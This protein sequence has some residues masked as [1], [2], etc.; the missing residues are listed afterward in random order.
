[1]AKDIVY[2]PGMQPEIKDMCQNCGQCAQFGR[3]NTREPMKSQPIPQYPWQFVSQDIFQFESSSYLVTVDHY[4]DFIELDE[5]D[6]TLSSTVIKHSKSHFARHGIPEVL[7]SDNG[8]QFVSSEFAAYCDLY[9]ITH[10]TSSPYWPRGNGKAESAVKIVKTFMKKCADMQLAPLTY[11]NTPQEGHSLSPAQRSMGG[12]TRL[13][14]PVSPEVLGPDKVVSKLVQSEIS[15]K[16]EKAKKFYDRKAGNEHPNVPIESYVYSKPC[17]RNR[18]SP[19]KYGQVV[20]KPTSRSYVISTSNS[21]VRRNRA[22]IRQ[23]ALPSPQVK[24]N[25]DIKLKMQLPEDPGNLQLSD[26][27]STAPEMQGQSQVLSKE[28]TSSSKE[29]NSSGDDSN[30]GSSLGTLYKTRFGRVVRSR[31]IFDPSG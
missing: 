12:R 5:L 23:A 21:T 22:Q 7:L 11:R 14:I 29:F 24:M 18:S 27:Q 20:R 8:P 25:D 19:W 13:N 16:R 4:S 17:P 6:N 15:L 1:M 31:K 10:I 30:E 26:S 3:E 2:W 9:G 28:P